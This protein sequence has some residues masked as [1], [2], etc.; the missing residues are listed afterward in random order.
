LGY[1]R[2]AVAFWIS[3][4]DRPVRPM[5]N[6]G[7]ISASRRQLARASTPSMPQ[8]YGRAAATMAARACAPTTAPTIMRRSWSIPTATASKRI[9]AAASPNWCAGMGLNN[10]SRRPGRLPWPVN[11]R[12][13]DA[14]ER[15]RA[16]CDHQDVEIDEPVTLALV[17]RSDA[18]PRA[19]LIADPRQRE[20]A[21]VAA[22][23]N[24]RP[25]HHV[26]GQR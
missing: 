21:H 22:D 25:E 4:A 10:G 24:P 18:R 13:D 19:E 15:R 20:I 6:Q 12:V 26:V 8:R 9:V 1:G 11:R 2:D 14:R 23:V 17:V 7:C 16:V 5:R 3:S